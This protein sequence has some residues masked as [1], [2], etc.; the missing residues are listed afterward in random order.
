MI[1]SWVDLV[2]RIRVGIIHDFLGD[3]GA[4]SGKERLELVAEEEQLVDI[5]RLGI[6]GRTSRRQRLATMDSLRCPV[7]QSF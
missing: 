7:A 4:E 6:D 3:E 2:I 5:K 1:I